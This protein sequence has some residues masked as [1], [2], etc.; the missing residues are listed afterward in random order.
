MAYIAYGQGIVEIE[1][2]KTDVK[3]KDIFVPIIYSPQYHGK[4]PT[5]ANTIDTKTIPDKISCK[6]Q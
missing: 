5:I 4:C 6:K 2:R 3:E 1:N